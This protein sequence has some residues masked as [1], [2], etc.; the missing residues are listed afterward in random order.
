[1]TNITRRNALGLGL[2]TALVLAT[3]GRAFAADPIKIGFPANLTGN[4]ASLDNP[5]LN[6]G[7]LAAAEINA[8]GGVLGQQ[9]ELVVYDTK[10]DATVISTVASQLIDDH[11]AVGPHAGMVKRKE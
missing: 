5:M 4:A 7:K 3:T 11:L 1:M 6:G 9:I 10:S 8:A 2:S